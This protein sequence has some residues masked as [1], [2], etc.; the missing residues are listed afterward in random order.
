MPNVKIDA[1]TR[2]LGL[3]QPEEG[4]SLSLTGI[5]R[6]VEARTRQRG[7]PV[8]VE[9]V[10]DLEAEWAELS[11]RA[12]SPPPADSD[13]LSTQAI[14][15]EYQ[16]RCLREDRAR[17]EFEG[18]RRSVAEAAEETARLAR[19]D[20]EPFWMRDIARMVMIATILLSVGAAVILAFPLA[21]LFA[22]P[23]TGLLHPDEILALSAVAGWVLSFGLMHTT[24]RFSVLAARTADRALVPIK[25]GLLMF[26]LLF[27][28]GFGLMRF[29]GGEQNLLLG[30]AWSGWEMA[31]FG[32]HAMAAFG[33]SRLVR[34]ASQALADRRELEARHH[35]RAEQLAEAQAQLEEAIEARQ[36]QLAVVQELEGRETARE[37]RE[38]LAG[39]TARLGVLTTTLAMRRELEEATAP[40]ELSSGEV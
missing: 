6:D 17:Q 25:G 30:V 37:R 34:S 24:A 39:T 33:G 2:P 21:E 26:E 23:L 22:P 32:V 7:L 29:A 4:M 35:H 1:F 19:A 15:A 12:G 8:Y 38:G 5:E 10:A 27:S 11:T 14:I 3:H 40:A 18:A 20:A 9:A 13:A 28:T 36:H 31:F 16:A